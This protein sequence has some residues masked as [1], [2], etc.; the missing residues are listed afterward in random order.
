MYIS[1][2]KREW[3]LRTKHLI[4]LIKDQVI[5]SFTFMPTITTLMNSSEITIHAADISKI[6][7]L[8]NHI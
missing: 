2:N 3:K 8:R 1:K 5:Q 7:L 6:Q 4:F